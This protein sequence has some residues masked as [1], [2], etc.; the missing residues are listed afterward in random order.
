MCDNGALQAHAPGR[1]RLCSGSFIVMYLFLGGLG[2]GVLLVASAGSL[3]FHALSN[4]TK[5]ESVAFR[6]LCGRC[7]AVGFVVACLG[8]LCL[9]CDLGRPDRFVLLFARPTATWLTFGTLSLSALI[10]VAGFLCIAGPLRAVNVALHTRR[11]AEVLCATASVL[12]MAYTGMF[13][14]QIKA[15]AFW[16][17]M[18]MP[19]LFIASAISMGLALC[20]VIAAATKGAQELR[21]LSARFHEMHAFVL[22]VE[23]CV[24]LAFFVSALEGRGTSPASV[25][26]LLAEPLN[27][28]FVGGVLALGLAVPLVSEIVQR[29]TGHVAKFPASDVLCIF[30]GFCLRYCLVAAGLH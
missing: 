5:R 18:L 29:A 25:M 26:L 7:Y 27:A 10:A 17:G 13:L 21:S 22:V 9:L 16:N 15:V 8:A 19:A 14:Q 23:A 24:L 12:V 20:A 11:A 2:S 30:G 1:G 6:T 28:W 4:R 3:G